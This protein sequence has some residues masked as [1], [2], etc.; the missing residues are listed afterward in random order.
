VSPR[1][2]TPPKIGGYKWNLE[3]SAIGV[4]RADV[5]EQLSWALSN[6]DQFDPH[7]LNII[8]KPAVHAVF[9]VLYHQVRPSYAALMYLRHTWFD[10][11]RGLRD[12]IVWQYA[13]M[14]R[15][16]P[17]PVA[18]SAEYGLWVDYFE[19]SEAAEVFASLMRLLPHDRWHRLLS[20]AGPVPWAAKREC[21]REAA[22]IPDLHAALAEGIDGSFYDVYGDVDAVEA[23]ELLTRIT[24]DDEQLRAALAEATTQPLRLRSGSAV[25]VTA[26]EWK[27]P[28]SFLLQLTIDGSRWR[29]VAGSELV[30]DDVVYGRLRHWDFPWRGNL[31]HV[32]VPDGDFDGERGLHRVE[33]PREHVEALVNRQ[34]EAWPPGLRDHV[35]SGQD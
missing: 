11:S 35:A 12:W 8:G 27:H 14:L 33:A 7:S 13:A 4:R 3:L 17:D 1:R 20:A 10:A 26:P 30:A 5:D 24:V 23:A 22:E 32:V 2:S 16:G 29:W 25:V 31:R 28:G 34:L 6:A 15:H 18:K 19:R 9:W 21:F